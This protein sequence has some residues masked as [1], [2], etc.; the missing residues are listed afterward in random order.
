[1]RFWTQ[2][3]I[4][5]TDFCCVLFFDASILDVMEKHESSKKREALEKRL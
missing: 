3:K 5:G 4:G 1:M 2:Q